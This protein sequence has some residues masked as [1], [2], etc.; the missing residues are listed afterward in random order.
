MYNTYVII[1]Q[2]NITNLV[3]IYD[4]FLPDEY[5]EYQYIYIA[6]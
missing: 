5:M 2:N 1:N 3:F 6:K 4:L